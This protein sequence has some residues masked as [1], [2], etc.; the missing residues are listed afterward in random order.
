M[1]SHPMK[2]FT[3]SAHPELAKEISDMVLLDDNYNTIVHAIEEGRG[4]YQN[5]RE[6]GQGPQGQAS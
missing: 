5:T 2:I 4:I 1:S 3:G 6:P